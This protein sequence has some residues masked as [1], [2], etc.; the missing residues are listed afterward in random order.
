MHYINLDNPEKETPKGNAYTTT[1]KA[2]MPHYKLYSSSSE[3]MS[4]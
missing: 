1:A 3:D 2:I 4:I